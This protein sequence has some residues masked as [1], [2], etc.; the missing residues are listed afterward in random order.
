[1]VGDYIDLKLRDAL[2]LA[3]DAQLLQA[4]ARA[5]TSWA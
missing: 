3:V 5:R 4:T 2:K 1:M